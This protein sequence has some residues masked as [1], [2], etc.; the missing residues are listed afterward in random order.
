MLLNHYIF[1]IALTY[2]AGNIVELTLSP[3]FSNKLAFEL[4]EGRFEVKT[5][6]LA[7]PFM[8]ALYFFI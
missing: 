1:V 3:T 8:E 5:F 7:I 4:K 6:W 2:K